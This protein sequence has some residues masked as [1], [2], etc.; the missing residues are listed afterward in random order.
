MSPEPAPPAP[1]TPED[2]SS[3][4]DGSD[5]DSD[6]A[7]AAGVNAHASGESD[8]RPVPGRPA[9]LGGN[10]V[11]SEQPETGSNDTGGGSAPEHSGST[12][13]LSENDSGSPTTAPQRPVY[14]QVAHVISGV[15]TGTVPSGGIQAG[16]GGTYGASPVA[17]LLLGSAALVLMVVA[18]GLVRRRDALRS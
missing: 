3:D 7:D 11:T 8:C 1:A 18:L 12:K 13:T 6:C 16:A 10:L 5:D 2:E 15:D 9:P 17:S 4:D 14:R